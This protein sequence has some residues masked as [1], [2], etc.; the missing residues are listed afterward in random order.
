M[1]TR[2]RRVL[3]AAVYTLGFLL[4]CAA[5]TQRGLDAPRSF[6]W[7]GIC[8]WSAYA[9]VAALLGWI[10]QQLR[11]REFRLIAAAGDPWPPDWFQWAMYASIGASFGLRGLNKLKR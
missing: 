2:Y 5:Q 3:T 8:E 9:L 6:L 1:D 4:L 11:T 10:A 7:G